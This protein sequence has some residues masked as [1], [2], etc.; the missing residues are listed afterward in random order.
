V[1]GPRGTVAYRLLPGDGP[2]VVLLAGLGS[3]SRLWGELPGLLAKRFSVL[4]PDNRGV[5]GSRDGAPFTLEGAADDAALAIADAG[6]GRAHVIGVSMGGQIACHLAA[7]DPGLVGRMVLASCALRLTPSHRRVLRFFELALRRL[8]PAEA[9]EA[10][11]GFAFGARFADAFPGFVDEAAR[12]WAP[13]PSDVPGALAQVA[14]LAAG[15]DLR[16]VAAA[17]RCPT[18]VLAG[19]ADPPVPPAATRALAAAI[20]GARFRSVPEAAHS[21]LAEGGPG[22]L[23]E[24]LGFL[25]A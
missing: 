20:P 1:A 22:L 12:L 16:P 5:G 14:H 10:L 3:T 9:G 18:L 4:A 19:E 6:L 25:A 24:I 17:V 21:V 15:Y 2:A 8:P 7:R 13:D 11:M 23:E